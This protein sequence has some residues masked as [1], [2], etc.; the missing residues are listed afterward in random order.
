MRL[1]TSGPRFQRLRKDPATLLAALGLMRSLRGAGLLRY[2]VA[3]YAIFVVPRGV[4]H[5]GVRSRSECDSFGRQRRLARRED[6]G[7]R[8]ESCKKNGTSHLP[9]SE[10][11]LKG[12]EVL[13]A[14]SIE[15]V[16]KDVRFAAAAGCLLRGE[17]PGLDK[18]R[19]PHAGDDAA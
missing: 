19:A 16:P 11:D 18:P 10:F 5:R 15:E 17:L 12:L 14:A 2:G 3:G 9:V 6:Q 1:D 8:C 13:I 4:P 7:A